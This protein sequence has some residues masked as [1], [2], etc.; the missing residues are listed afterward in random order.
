M[1]IRDRYNTSGDVIKKLTGYTYSAWSSAA[2][3]DGGFVSNG[4]QYPFQLRSATCNGIAAPIT[5]GNCLGTLAALKQFYPIPTTT[6]TG[7]KGSYISIGDT[8]N[9][10]Q[11]LPQG[12]C[13]KS[14]NGQYIAAMQTDGNFVQYAT[15]KSNAPWATGTNGKGSGSPYRLILQSDGNLC[16]YDTKYN[17]V[18]CSGTTGKGGVYLKLQNDGNLVLYKSDNKT[19]VWATNMLKYY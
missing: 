9:M 16:V 11:A 1:C 10:L 14:P 3:Y 15:S 17:N 13:L 2:D 4:Y 19:A 8:L 6:I 18:W 12:F 7:Y 5:T